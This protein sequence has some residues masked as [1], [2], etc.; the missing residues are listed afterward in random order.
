[1]S[2]QDQGASSATG[3]APSWRDFLTDEEIESLEGLLQA[4]ASLRARLKEIARW[5][6]R[7]VKRADTRR[8]RKVG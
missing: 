4:R 3:R 7:I 6:G 2:G 8:A 5:H 1:M